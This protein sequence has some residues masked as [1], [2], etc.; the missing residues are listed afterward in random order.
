MSQE[1]SAYYWL[2]QGYTGNDTRFGGGGSTD[3]PSRASHMLGMP[4]N[5]VV[6]SAASE[7]SGRGLPKGQIAGGAN[8]Y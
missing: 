5:I 4:L 3:G 2:L 8:K 6:T 1:D 7:S